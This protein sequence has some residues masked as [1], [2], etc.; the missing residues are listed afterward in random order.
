MYCD[1]CGN[2]LDNSNIICPRCGL[3]VGR[4][5]YKKI[6]KKKN[7]NNNVRGLICLLFGIIC[8]LMCFNFMLKDI[9][10]VGMYTT[11]NDRLF[12]AMDLVLAPLLL[13]FI[14]LVIS[15]TNKN[16]DNAFNK[17]GIFL[18]I[19]SVF[20]ILTEIVIVMIY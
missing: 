16:S 20:F 19:V 11:I 12:Y 15:C 10:I 6:R 13:S 8:L 17:V 3:L 9:S 2:K 14:S 5:Q 18:S 7:S 1:N 4:S